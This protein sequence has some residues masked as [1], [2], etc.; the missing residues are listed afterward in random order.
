MAMPRVTAAEV[1]HTVV[2]LAAKA[3]A[4]MPDEPTFRRL[5]AASSGRFACAA[6][7]PWR[8]QLRDFERDEAEIDADGER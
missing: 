2:V 1:I 4:F 8:R 5:P 3:K 6:S 7:R